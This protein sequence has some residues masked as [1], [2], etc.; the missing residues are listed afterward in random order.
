MKFFQSTQSLTRRTFWTLSAPLFLL[1][2]VLAVP[3]VG[4][5]LYLLIHTHL[6]EN[7]PVQQGSTPPPCYRNGVDIAA[8]QANYGIT[9]LA[10]GIANLFLAFLAVRAI[11]P[12][13]L[14]YGWITAIALSA[15]ACALT[16]TR[17]AD[18]DV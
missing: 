3:L 1:Y 13:H 6:G 8:L 2:A 17:S 7:C 9:I 4:N 15:A 11:V 16:R 18:Q 5:F 14:L 10:M 12:G